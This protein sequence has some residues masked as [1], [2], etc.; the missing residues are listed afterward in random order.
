MEQRERS[1]DA[2]LTRSRFAFGSESV[3]ID[4]VDLEDGRF[5]AARR[6]VGRALLV[7]G[8]LRPDAKVVTSALDNA[9]PL[10]L[11]D[12]PVPSAVVPGG[13]A[14]LSPVR[15]LEDDTVVADGIGRR[16]SIEG[17]EL[18]PIKS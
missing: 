13:N 6:V 15:R 2:W 8:R 14:N 10:V 18:F 11:G 12:V 7:S 3:E 1:R 16:D 17:G 4:P 9:S 5:Q